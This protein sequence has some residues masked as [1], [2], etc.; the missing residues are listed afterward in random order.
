MIAKIQVSRIDWHGITV[1]IRYEP[2]WSLA[3]NSAYGWSMAHI[4]LHVI[5][6]ERAKLPVTDT[7]YRSHFVPNSVVIDAG[8]A[9]AFVRAW[10]DDEAQTPAWKDA[11]Q[12]SFL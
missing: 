9:I 5:D 2:S 10:L 11:R 8:G 4:E 6:P 1:E 7:G 3:M 12:L